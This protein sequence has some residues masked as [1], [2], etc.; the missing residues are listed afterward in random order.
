MCYH[1]R[2]HLSLNFHSLAYHKVANSRPCYYYKNGLVL[3]QNRFTQHLFYFMGGDTNE[4][5]LVFATFGIY[6]K[7]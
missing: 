6:M 5:M 4:D 2:A 1:K 3:V 7:L